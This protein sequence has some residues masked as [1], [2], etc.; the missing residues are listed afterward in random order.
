MLSDIPLFGCVHGGGDSWGKGV[1]ANIEK[2]I[3]SWKVAVNRWRLVYPVHFTGTG[4]SVS[5][6]LQNSA[7]YGEGIQKHLLNWGEYFCFGG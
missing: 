7:L 6:A 1:K 5:S 3:L 2:Q 4:W